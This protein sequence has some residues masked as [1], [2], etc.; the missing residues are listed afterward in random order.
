VDFENADCASLLDGDLVVMPRLE[1]W[2]TIL[3][4]VGI[5]VHQR[6]V[7]DLRCIARRRHRGQGKNTDEKESERRNAI[8]KRTQRRMR[9][10]I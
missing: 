6:F 7:L 1:D 5:S 2:S 8:G 4:F 10:L 9:S 3:R